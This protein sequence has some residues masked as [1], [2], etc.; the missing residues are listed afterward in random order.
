VPR[1]IYG[2]TKTAAQ[3]LCELFHQLHKLPCLVLRTSRFFPEVDDDAEYEEEYARRGWRMF[4][5]IERVCVNERA[6]RH[7]GW[8]PRYDFRQVVE[9]LKAGDDFRSPLARAVGAKGYHDRTLADAP[10]PR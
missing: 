7:L 9:A 5:R 8:C 3:D 2:V 6:R 10:A 1:N 4:P